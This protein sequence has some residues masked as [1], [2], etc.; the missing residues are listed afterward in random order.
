MKFYT[1]LLAIIL[2]TLPAYAGVLKGKVTDTKG[3]LLPFATVYIQGTTNGTT[4]NA[5]A[6]YQLNLA[7]GSYKVTCQYMGF[8]ASVYSVTIKGDEI[9]NHNFSLQDQS[10]QMKDVVIKAN[11]EDPAY[12]IIRKT[13]AKRKFHLQQVKSFQADI[14][15]KGV[16]RTRETPKRI[17]GEKI[18][19]GDL[20]VDSAGKGIL[21]LCEEQAD[22]YSDGD[23]QRTV[24]KAVRE[25]GEANGLGMSQL[26]S[27]VTFYENNVSIFKGINPRGF[28]S[29]I[30][31]NALFYYRYK[32]EGN[33]MDNGH[34]VARIKV[35]PKRSYEPLFQ[36]TIYIVEEDWAIHSIDLLVTKTANLEL[37]DT[38][39][40]QQAHLLLKQDTWVVKSQV[41]YPTVKIFG[42][43]ITGHFV[44]V[45]NG[46][47]VNEPMPD[48]IF[49]TNITSQYEHDA[50]KKDTAYWVN[51]PVPLE[52]DESRDFIV[53]DSV[54]L[55]YED[56]AYR[57]SMRRKY[58]KIDFM[59]IVLSGINLSTKEYKHR[60]VSN[61]I[62][63]GLV[64]YNTIEG[65]NIVPKIGWT[66]T[67]DTGYSLVTK[68]AARYGFSN[69]HFNLIGRTYYIQQN[70]AWRGKWWRVGIEGGKYAFQYNY[71]STI[72]PLYNTF[73]TLVYAEN[74][75][76]L[77]ERW[78]AAV[79][80]EKNFGNGLR[81]DVK[82]DYQ[83]RMPL[84]NTTDYTWSKK[85]NLTDNVPEAL[86]SYTWE[87]HDAALLKLGVTYR[88]GYTYTQ[89]PDYKV[90]NGSNLPLFSLVYE[91][92]LP[93]VGNSKADFDKWR[94]SIE[95]DMNLKL[96]G[97]LSY[98][99]AAGGFLNDKY[100]SLP[101]LMHLAD[102]QLLLAAPYL[103][104]FQLANYYRNSN[105]EKIYGE[106]H[107]EYYMKGLLTNK[108]PLLKQARWY[109]VLGSNTFYA[110]NHNYYVETFAGIDNL[111]FKA[112]RFLRVDFVYAWDKF[113]QTSYGFRVGIDPTGILRGGFG[114]GNDGDGW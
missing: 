83:T 62:I 13:I 15:L 74:H 108:I 67:I 35:M 79:F 61:S 92:G 107:F 105:T 11:G 96:L 78:N 87:R 2:Y 25:S 26:P 16:L 36:G 29:P 1:L 53:K 34:M 64:N 12:P 7:P 18:D 90:A 38:L 33:F 93:A 75:M 6:E 102:N 95:D 30:S 43:D 88:P 56:P 55:R 45:Y 32:F 50:N 112:L 109:L 113:N 17:M 63:N 85:E 58:N 54:R 60:F 48:T 97:S 3:E 51:R 57:D 66:Y 91:K 41:L 100:V 94:F 23:R 84:Q 89:Y 27:I 80:Y 4:T 103:N 71:R 44:T 81:F 69:T 24:I 8:K 40:V 22:Y 104:S 9:I 77:Y 73:N 46:Q 39:K 65:L 72:T 59:D 49:N 82:A 114:L 14:Y 110:G 5:E 99:I 70:R 37:L 98:K 86:K 10:L 31:E 52:A 76:K 42:F 47:K 106:L 19:N 21:Y 20:G 28:I 111:G 68:V 101:D